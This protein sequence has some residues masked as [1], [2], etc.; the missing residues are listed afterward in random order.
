MDRALVEAA[1]SG[2]EEAFASIARG[3]ADR[4][5][6]VAHRIL[7]DVG[8]AGDV[9]GTRVLVFGR[10]FPDTSAADRAELN[11]ILDSMQIEAIASPSASPSGAP[12]IVP[13][14]VPTAAP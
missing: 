1:R 2:D 7:R 8:R 3:S 9:D 5:F 10:S 14:V 12:S 13:S 4:L 11:A 6:A